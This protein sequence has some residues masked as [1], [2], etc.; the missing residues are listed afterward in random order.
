[1]GNND[2]MIIFRSHTSWGQNVYVDN[3]NLNG[4]STVDV[5][6]DEKK[7]V[8]MVFP[9]PV[10]K[11]SVLHLHSDLNEKV[12]VE[13]YSPDGKQVYKHSH[14]PISDISIPDVSI[15]TYLVVLT[16]SKLIKKQV[17]IFQ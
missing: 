15:G 10:S 3:I 2:V 16:T 17:L 1:M 7:N 5:A 8:L 14:Q 4:T 13:V 11:N 12:M 6:S 9:N